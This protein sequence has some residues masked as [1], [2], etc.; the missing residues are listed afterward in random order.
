MTLPKYSSRERAI[1]TERFQAEDIEAVFVEDKTSAGP[2]SLIGVAG[3]KN[4]T[5]IWL[6][7]R[8]NSK[9]I[10]VGILVRQLGCIASFNQ[11]HPN[12]WQLRQL[13]G[14]IIGETPDQVAY[15]STVHIKDENLGH[16]NM[17]RHLK[18]PKHPDSD[19]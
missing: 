16:P 10:P 7:D 4:F 18:L 11:T 3:Y 5:D 9:V 1:L 12:S 6:A 15:S 8:F 19:I 13:A 14:D 2:D 17:P